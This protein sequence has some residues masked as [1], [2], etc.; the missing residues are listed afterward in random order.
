VPHYSSPLSFT[1]VLPQDAESD[2]CPPSAAKEESPLRPEEDIPQ[3]TRALYSQNTPPYILI[4]TKSYA[5]VGNAK[6]SLGTP[7]SDADSTESNGDSEED[8]DDESEMDDSDWSG[9]NNYFETA[10]LQAVYPNLELAAHL[11]TQL[12]SLLLPGSSKISRKVTF[13]RERLTNRAL[14]TSLAT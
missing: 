5:D 14:L 7:A 8:S 1:S 13:W 12:H 2:C 10:I 9:E 11:I 6:T 3:S 4:A